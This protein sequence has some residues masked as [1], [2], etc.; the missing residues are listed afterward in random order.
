MGI[1]DMHRSAIEDKMTARYIQTIYEIVAS[2]VLGQNLTR[3]GRTL[4]LNDEVRQRIIDLNH[5]RRRT[6]QRK[7]IQVQTTVIRR[8]IVD[9]TGNMLQETNRNVRTAQSRLG[10][11]IRQTIYLLRGGRGNYFCHR[12]CKYPCAIDIVVI[13]LYIGCIQR[14]IETNRAIP[15][16]G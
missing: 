9:G 11:S 15:C 1:L 3:S 8:G 13:H 12:R 2:T 5:I 4:V 7:A 10:D 6:R 14:I 16:H